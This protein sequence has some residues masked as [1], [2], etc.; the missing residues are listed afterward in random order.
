ELRRL[1]LTRDTEAR[2]REAM[3][4]RTGMLVVEQVIPQSAADGKLIPGDVLVEVDGKLVTEFVPLAAALDNAVGG[5]VTVVVERGG[6]R[7]EHRLRVDDLHAIT[8]AE[9][10]EYGDGVF[11][12]LSYQ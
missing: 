8:P 10:I 4:N 3:P 7:I 12:T 5:E 1:G 11:H 2:V 6:E 9:Y